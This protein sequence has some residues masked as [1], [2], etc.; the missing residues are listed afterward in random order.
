MEQHDSP[1]WKKLMWLVVIWAA[2]V[3]AL[4]AVSMV[5]RLLMSAAGLKAH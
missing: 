4:G 1:R 2:S 5:L 3:L